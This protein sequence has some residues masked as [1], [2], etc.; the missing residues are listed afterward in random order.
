[1]KS[2]PARKQ[3]AASASATRRSSKRRALTTARQAHAKETPRNQRIPVGKENSKAADAF[4]IM[5]SRLNRMS[6]RSAA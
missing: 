3:R 6:L 2:Q 5:A 1:M 4:Q